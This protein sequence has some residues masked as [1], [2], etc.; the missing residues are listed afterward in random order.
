M[1]ALY[2]HL[3]S[4]TAGLVDLSLV[5]RVRYVLSDRYTYH[6]QVNDLMDHIE[7]M[8][9]RPRGIRPTG[10]V[11]SSPS[12]GGKTAFGHAVLRK[13][14]ARPA[15]ALRAA[16][17]PFVM[18]SMSDAREANEI[19]RRFLIGL[20]VPH[21]SSMTARQ[22]RHLALQLGDAVDLRLII[23][24]EIQDV[25]SATTRQQQLALLAI[26]DLMNSLK[27]PVLALG[28]ETAR[29]ALEADQHLKARFEFRELPSWRVDDYLRHFLESYEESL[30]LK[31]RSN[32][33]SQRVMKLLIKESK[34]VL[35]VIVERLKRAA[36]FA[37]ED[38]TEQ[39]TIELIERARD[40]V[41]RT[42][43]EIV[44]E[45]RAEEGL[46]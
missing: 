45:A 17:Q 37:I 8:V 2:P 21:A 16:S 33:G 24:D 32:L 39:I 41:P 20:G 42:D 46:A 44:E 15:T 12:N 3:P 4:A 13:F 30:P 28:T 1:S 23:I 40:R 29:H 38:G 5:E 18:I 31:K 6:E 22:C 43:L 10:F 34:G 11:I 36:A 35:G 9:H 7:F 14:K 19:Y 25:L 27:V 26:K